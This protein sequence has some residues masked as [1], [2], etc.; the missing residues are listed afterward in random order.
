MSLFQ[1]PNMNQSISIEKNKSPA[2]VDMPDTHVHPYYELYLLLSGER[3]YLMGHKLYDIAPGNLVVIPKNEIHK[4]LSRNRK[5]YERYVLYFDDHSIE[6]LTAT[7]G[8]DRIEAFF[9]SGCLTFSPEYANKLKKN[10]DFIFA[11]KTVA[12]EL[13]YSVQK[14][15]LYDMILTALR[16]GRKKH[17]TTDDGAD[18]IQLV[19]RY[20]SEHYGSE[21]TLH[22]A[23]SIAC[24]EDTY[25]SKRFKALTGF[26]FSEY[27][28]QTRIKAAEALLLS[29]ELT[30]SEISDLCGF[31]SSNYF[32][33]VFK[34]I[35]GHPP[36]EYRKQNKL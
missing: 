31:S 34:G 17:C 33:D 3:R 7:V 29:T 14:N 18:K 8:Q 9:N 15:L 19:A 35:N 22:H 10:M 27:L 5:G 20:I 30:V 16:H 32:G 28:T 12:D 21:I 2:A 25:F 23:A 36:S 11:E 1:L 26:C 24:M 4:T 6:D 13:S